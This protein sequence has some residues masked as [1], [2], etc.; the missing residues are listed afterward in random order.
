MPALQPGVYRFSPRE[1][2]K[3]NL[4]FGRVEAD[5]EVYCYDSLTNRGRPIAPSR[6]VLIQFNGDSVL[7]IDGQ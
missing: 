6:I 5:G 2:G 3:V 4:D 1:S 7:R